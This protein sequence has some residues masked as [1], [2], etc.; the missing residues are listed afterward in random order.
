MKKNS[1][2]FLL[3]LLVI[4]CP[5]DDKPSVPPDVEI[6]EEIMG[7]AHVGYYYTSASTTFTKEQE[8]ALTDEMGIV[9][10]LRDFSW[11]TVEPTQGN[12]S[13]STFDTYVQDAKENNKKIV[14][15]LDYDVSWIH[16]ETCGHPSQDANGDRVF[17]RVVAGE[18]EVA[19]FCEYTRKTVERYKDDVG[20]WCIWNEPNLTDRFWSGTPE[21][22]FTLTKATADA[23]RE[24]APNAVILGGAFNTLVDN[25]T[26]TK[27]IF[28]SG[29]MD[30]IDYIAYH[31][32]MPDAVRTG[33]VYTQFRDSVAKYGFADKIWITE[34]G[35]PLNMGSGGYS[36]K[37]KE[38]DMPDTTVKTIAILAAEGAR[39]ILWY[40]MFDHGA[41]GDPNDSEHWFGLVNRDTITKRPGGEAYQIAANNIPGKTL[42][43]SRLE[44]SGLPDYIA[45]YYFEGANG[46]HSLVIWNNRQSRSQSV[47]VTLP[48]TNQKVW[49]VATGDFS[50][51]GETSAWTLKTRDG[52]NKPLQFFTWENSDLSKKPRIAAQ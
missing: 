23:I 18:D 40:E 13:W 26:W 32:Y 34:V 33:A 30:K 21:E 44:T 19:A 28:E 16:T 27:G 52:D 50:P 8:Y 25:D 43:H 3:A 41:T 46:E 9:W 31:P 15:I 14:G 24:V 11:S 47:Q 12:W 45:A 37:I 4:S 48:G 17:R 42:R 51:L 38:E 22:F 5:N 20:A 39:V 10:M 6:P 35:Y 36:T 2:L 29:A 1:L 49:N 7:M